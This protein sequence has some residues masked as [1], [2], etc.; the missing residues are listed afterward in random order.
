MLKIAYSEIFCHLLPPGHRFPMAKYRLLPE[1]LLYEGIAD[2]ANFF[3][4]TPIS[5]E[6]V[7]KVHTDEYFDRLTHG[8][9]TKREERVSGFPHSPG[10]IQRELE[11]THGTLQAVALAQKF[12]VA[13]NTAGG[14]HH[15]YADHGEGFCLLND[16]AIAAHYAMD[17][18]NIQ[19]ILITDLDVHQG[20]G[21]AKI[22]E[23]DPRVFTFS[24]HGKSN[25]PHRKEKSDLDIA[26][27]DNTED[28]EYLGVLKKTLPDLLEEQRPQL[29]FFQ[30][31]VDV[32]KTDKLGRLALSIEGCK[33]RDKFVFE[34]AE[35]NGIPVVFMM[36][37]GYSA[38]LATIV[39]A[40]T[41]TFREARD[42]FF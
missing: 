5:K 14:T 31:G 10:L 6:H 41:N 24:M 35:K 25:Y 3:E 20:N 8:K 26:L 28:R 42:R 23:N 39:N 18:L 1:Q 16:A 32:L 11:I 37:G 7:L 34:Q 33:Q 17:H 22:F 4:P 12:G 30:A 21:T 19:R 9:L 29:L 15:G 36:G 27:P 40:H 2:R 13:A 38:Q